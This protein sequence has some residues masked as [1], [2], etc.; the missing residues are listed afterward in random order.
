MQP[1]GYSRKGPRRRV[2]ATGVGCT[3]RLARYAGGVLLQAKGRPMGD[4][5]E[6]SLFIRLRGSR[7]LTFTFG[8]LHLGAFACALANHLPLGVRLLVVVWVA[9]SAWYCIP[10]HA[11]GRAARAIVL[12]VWDRQGQWRLVQ[13]DGQGLDAWLDHG[14][15]SHPMLVALPFR[16]RVGHRRCVLV[17]PDRVDADHMR[18]L[19]VRLRCA[20]VRSG[21]RGD[22][23]T[24]C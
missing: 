13:R 23:G 19:R 10:L 20:S 15:Y 7:Q 17:V 5:H 9:L 6:N 1:G 4:W 21:G 18:R 14:A 8:G 12:I 3:N 22:P 16:T 24:V 2:T 11:T